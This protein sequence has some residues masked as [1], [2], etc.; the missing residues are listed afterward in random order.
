MAMRLRPGILLALLAGPVGAEPAADCAGL[1]GL[2]EAA[3]GSSLTAPPAAMDGGWCVLDGARSAG[4]GAVRVAVE[5]LRIRGETAGDTLLAL[6]IVAEG[7]RVTPALTERDMAGWLRDLLRM[8][9]ASVHL[10]LRRDEAGDRLLVETGRL[11][12]SGGSELVLTAEVAGAGLSAASLLAGRVTDLHLEWKN[13]GRTLRPVMEAMGAGLEPGATGTQAVLASRAALTAG[14][15]A[16]PGD[17]LPDDAAEALAGF[18]TALPQGRGRL[19][20]DLGAEP[21]IGAVEL[22]LLALAEDPMAPEA[23]ARLFRGVQV[24]AGWTPGMAP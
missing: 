12:L 17:S 10:A 20:L 14:I 8:Q 19:V 1:V 13:D 3:T 18:V 6:E 2:V 23:L 21:G 24:G 9:T 4:E 11:G 5:R 7:V 16:L 15:A 22:G